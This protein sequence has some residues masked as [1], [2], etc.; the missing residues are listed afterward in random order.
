VSDASAAGQ[1]SASC[2][3]SDAWVYVD[4]KLIGCFEMPVTVPVLWEGV[5]T[6]KIRPGIKINGIA[7]TRAPYPFYNEWI[8]SVTL[9]AGEVVT[10]NPTTT[11]TTNTHF[12]KID[13][14]ESGNNY[15]K[16]LSSDTNLQIIASPNPNVFEGTHSAITYLDNSRPSFY[17]DIAMKDSISLQGTVFLEFNYKS[18]QEFV[19]ALEGYG[20]A[21]YAPLEILTF[22]PTT[23][24]KKEYLYVTPAVA[25]EPAVSTA[26]M[27]YRLH[28]QMMNTYGADSLALVLDNLKIVTQ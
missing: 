7:A 23:E 6:V 28:F 1:G 10:I 16:T 21:Y 11:Y 24:W 20:G 4:E 27:F 19:V 18:N 3:I 2:N 5:R 12:L 9:K 17:S 25:R 26:L 14:F 22:N 15:K 8:Q 13:D